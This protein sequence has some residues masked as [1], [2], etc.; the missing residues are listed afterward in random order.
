M[1]NNFLITH[2]LKQVAR[3]ALVI[4]ETLAGKCGSA[5]LE[6]FKFYL[7]SG[8]ICGKVLDS[9]SISVISFQEH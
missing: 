4:L 7:L 5:I 9:T 1:L 2:L 6:T 8:K 3:I